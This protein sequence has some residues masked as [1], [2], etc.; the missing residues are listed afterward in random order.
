[1]RTPFSCRLVVVPGTSSQLSLVPEF[2][3]TWRML[4]YP[5]PVCAA[6]KPLCQQPLI[7]TPQHFYYF[8]EADT[9]SSVTYTTL[10]YNILLTFQEQLL[11]TLFANLHFTCIFLNIKTISCSTTLEM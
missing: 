4:W 5:Q 11:A 8:V 1:L 3:Q 2:S 9:A 10:M 6:G 7:F